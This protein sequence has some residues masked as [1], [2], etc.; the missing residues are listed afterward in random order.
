MPSIFLKVPTHFFQNSF[1]FHRMISQM[2]LLEI[3]GFYL[4]QTG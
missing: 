4:K 1:A 3:T 2:V